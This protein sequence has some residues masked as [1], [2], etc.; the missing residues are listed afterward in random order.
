[1]TIRK[2]ELSRFAIAAVCL[3]GNLMVLSLI[4]CLTEQT[5]SETWE[6]TTATVYAVDNLVSDGDTTGATLAETPGW[7]EALTD[8]QA[9]EDPHIAKQPDDFSARQGD[10]IEFSVVAEGAVSYHW[11]CSDSGSDSWYES[12]AGDPSSSTLSFELTP[13]LTWLKNCAFRCRV[14]FADGAVE[15]SDVVRIEYRDMT[16]WLS[17]ARRFAHTAEFLPVGV[18]TAGFMLAVVRR[19]MKLRRVVM[20]ALAFCFLCSLGDQVHKLF[21]PGREFDCLDLVL[22]AIG[23]LTGIGLA[24]VL[25]GIVHKFVRHACQTP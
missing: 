23:Y 7:A 3:M 24:V 22:D 16:T 1:M 8:A 14:T 9:F 13:G 10:T 18:F 17:Y 5:P 15:Y 4:W 25:G 12:P 21:V 20:I 6:T 19:S 2:K 11:E